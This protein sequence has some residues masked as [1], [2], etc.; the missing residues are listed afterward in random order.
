MYLS[1]IMLLETGLSDN[2]ND[3]FSLLTFTVELI[4]TGQQYYYNRWNVL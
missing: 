2:F 4:A 1:L 3:K